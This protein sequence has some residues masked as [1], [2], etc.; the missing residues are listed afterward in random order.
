M[1]S[2]VISGLV[3]GTGRNQIPLQTL[4][5]TTETAFLVNT[6]AGT[7]AA[8]VTVPAGA[9]IGGSVTPLDPNVTNSAYLS[10]GPRQYGPPGGTSRPHY[11]S[12]SWNGRAFKVRI[13]GTGAAVANAGN[14]L[15]LNLYQGTTIGGTL[16]G[17]TGTNTIATASTAPLNFIIEATLIWDATTQSLTGM[18]WYNVNYNSTQPTHAFSGPAAILNIPTVAAVANLTFVASAKWGNAAGGTIQVV[19]FLVEEV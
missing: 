3:G 6:D 15:E 18:Q 19:E 10:N 9:G 17:G 16:I 11:N 12:S 13:N 4:A 8:I 2:N 1:N 14:T 7:A 5:A